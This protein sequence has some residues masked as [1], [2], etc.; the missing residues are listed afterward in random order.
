[1]RWFTLSL[2]ALTLPVS[3]TASEPEVSVRARVLRSTTAAQSDNMQSENAPDEPSAAATVAQGLLPQYQSAGAF[4][5]DAAQAPDPNKRSLRFLLALP[6]QLLLLEAFVTIDG[7]PYEMV[8]EQ[9]IARLLEQLKKEPAAE[10][11]APTSAQETVSTP[12]DESTPESEQAEEASQGEAVSVPVPSTTLEARLGRYA[13]VTGRDPTSAEVR[14]LLA[15]WVDGPALLMLDENFQRYRGSQTPALDVLDRDIDGKISPDELS[16]A[17]Q[18]LLSCDVNQNDVIEFTEIAEVADDPR[19]KRG[20]AT[21]QS[22]IPILA[23]TSVAKAFRRLDKHSMSA[24]TTARLDTNGNGEL[25]ESEFANL[26]EM[27]P[28]V[29]VAV[30]FDTKNAKDSAIRVTQISSQLAA[31]ASGNVGR[32]ISIPVGRTSLEF[33]AVQS[34]AM[35]GSDQISV[36]IINDGYPLLPALDPNDD[37]RLTIRELRNVSDH[38]Q[39]FDTNQDSGISPDEISSTVRVAFG[40]GPCVHRHLAD[41]RSV[42]VRSSAPQVVAPEWFTQMDG[43][44]DGDLSPREFLLDA[45]KFKQ[46]DSDQDGLISP[47]EAVQIVKQEPQDVIQQT[48]STLEEATTSP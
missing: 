19:R 37:G 32:S 46:L 33:S 23:A 9:R 18:T 31:E 4:R 7:Q 44:K 20:P 25:D 6:D 45:E 15:K 1:M 34:I 41:I 14:W 39:R 13:R 2:V 5:S 27:A 10:N 16:A 48:K 38:L 28:D 24:E 3:L 42:H 35:S 26:N 36:G 21:R 40:L 8:R 17:Q 43:N 30:S 12:E 29:I 11:A 22:L 47:A